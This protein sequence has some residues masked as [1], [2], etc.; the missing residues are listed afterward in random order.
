MRTVNAQRRRMVAVLERLQRAGRA[1][2]AHRSSRRERGDHEASHRSR[3]P[4][5][6]AHRRH[7]SRPRAPS[8]E[9]SGYKDALV[10]RRHSVRL[11]SSLY[12]GD[13]S[14]QSGADAMEQLLTLDE[15]PTAVFAGNDEMA[16]GAVKTA[17]SHGLVRSGR[18]VD[19]RL[20]RS[21]HRRLLQPAA[22][23]D[24]HAVSGDRPPR[25]SGADRSRSQVAMWRARSCC[26]RS[27]SFATAPRL[28]GPR[29]RT[30][31]TPK[32][33]ATRA[34][35]TPEHARFSVVA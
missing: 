30:R 14:M 26:R 25:H 24:S 33:C 31:R 15:P 16:F 4:P 27:S 20:R 29:R 9:S 17:R 18:P 23:D 22:H 5:D 35:D 13:F 32:A 28:R 1:G 19:G 12:A 8:I 3:P 2:R 34:V 21:D 7:A 11:P 10:G 6:R